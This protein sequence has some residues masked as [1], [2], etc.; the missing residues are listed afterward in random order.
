VKTNSLKATAAL[1]AIAL[2]CLNTHAALASLVELTARPDTGD[3]IFWGTPSQ[4]PV[5]SPLSF[6][7][8]GGTTGTVDLNG[9]GGLFEQCCIGANGNFNGNFAPGD[10]V[11]VTIPSN[12]HGPL[13]IN[14]N[15]P[16]Q[17][18]GTQIQHNLTGGSYTAEIFAFNGS[19][20]LGSFTENGMAGDVGDNSNIFLGVEDA[21]ADIT[22]VTYLTFTSN[23]FTFQQV[24]INQVTIDAPAATP[25][26]ATLPLFAGG[27]G[28]LALLGWRRKRKAQ[29]AAC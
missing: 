2:T 24:A 12:N 23:P 10:T 4:T 7:S 3:T 19:T 27:L 16:V 5:T 28:A 13:S 25:L 21:T 11:L 26:P 9:D 8:T 14:F 20:L 18:V 6:T 17:I 15:T 29:A 1:L 22:S